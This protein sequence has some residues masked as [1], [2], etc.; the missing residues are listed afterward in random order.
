MTKITPTT[1]SSSIQRMIGGDFHS[2]PD[3][4]IRQVN[5]DNN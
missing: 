4:H 1:V 5:N 3:D 2:H